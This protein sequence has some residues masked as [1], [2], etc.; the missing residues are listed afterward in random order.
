V[1]D[2]EIVWALVDDTNGN[3]QHIVANGVD[4]DEV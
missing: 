1:I 3:V 4:F 2:A